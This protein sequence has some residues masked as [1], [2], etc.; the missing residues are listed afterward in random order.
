MYLV[1]CLGYSASKNGV[2]LKPGYGS[3]KVIENGAVRCIYDF[4]GRPCRDVVDW[5]LA[6][7][8]CELR[9]KEGCI[10]ALQLLLNTNM[11]P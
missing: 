8:V 10:F 6:G 3:F 7:H 9:I 5:S 11:K 1:P 4:C 2:T